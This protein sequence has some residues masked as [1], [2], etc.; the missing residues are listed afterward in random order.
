MSGW[1]HGRVCGC[2]DGCTKSRFA[3][4]I[5]SHICTYPCTHIT[6]PMISTHVSTHRGILY[7]YASSSNRTYK[8]RNHPPNPAYILAC[9]SVHICTHT[10]L[11]IHIHHVHPPTRDRP[12][13]APFSKI[14]TDAA[15]VHVAATC[16]KVPSRHVIGSL[17][18]WHSRTGHTPQHHRIQTI[19]KSLLRPDLE[20]KHAITTK[21]KLGEN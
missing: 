7:E 2:M 10:H 12:Q 9:S 8:L 13:E 21:I 4:V 3:C 14:G 1:L 17:H 16:F 6:I 15:A 11:Y 18:F 5:A 20:P 19:T